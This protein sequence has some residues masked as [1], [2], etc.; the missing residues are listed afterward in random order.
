MGRTNKKQHENWSKLIHDIIYDFLP[1]HSVCKYMRSAFF[2]Q[3]AIH[4]TDFGLSIEHRWLCCC[5]AFRLAI[6]HRNF[7]YLHEANI[8]CFFSFPFSLCTSNVLFT[9][10]QLM[11]VLV[12][13]APFLC[14]QA[15]LKK[16]IRTTTN[17]YRFYWIISQKKFCFCISSFIVLKQRLNWF[18]SFHLILSSCFRLFIY[19]FISK[20]V[21]QSHEIGIQN[22]QRK[23]TMHIYIF[24]LL[25]DK[26]TYYPFNESSKPEKSAAMNW[27]NMRKNCFLCGE[28]IYD[29][30]RN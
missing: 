20:N 8:L 25:I 30:H 22:K 5:F 21:F 1:Y 15:K 7:Q 26:H 28:I 10:A 16:I 27:T 19:L 3:L 6:N 29:F 12:F 4:S 14:R 13:Y 23:K 24:R 18:Y 9:V 2:L 17:H 11:N